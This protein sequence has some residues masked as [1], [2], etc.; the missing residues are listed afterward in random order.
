[1][2]MYYIYINSSLSSINFCKII[3]FSSSSYISSTTL[4]TVLEQWRDTMLSTQIQILTTHAFWCQYLQKQQEHNGIEQF[5]KTIKEMEQFSCK[6]IRDCETTRL[7]ANR[8]VAKLFLI[9]YYQDLIRQTPKDGEPDT[10]EKVC[11]RMV[12]KYTWLKEQRIFC[13]TS[14]MQQGMLMILIIY[15]HYLHMLFP[16]QNDASHHK[17]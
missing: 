10:V 1:M 4:E 14:K 7:K 17:H 3:N 15:N 8:E 2:H 13:C 11:D 6:Q 12:I 9:Q 16:M 5:Q